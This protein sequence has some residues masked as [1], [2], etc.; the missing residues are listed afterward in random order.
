MVRFKIK[1]QSGWRAI[2]KRGFTSIEDAKIY[3]GKIRKLR[4]NNRFTPD[5][6]TTEIFKNVA[7]RRL[8]RNSKII[9]EAWDHEDLPRAGVYFI[10]PSAGGLIKIGYTDD[11]YKRFRQ[12]QYQC[13]VPLKVLGV[14]PGDTILEISFHMDFI[15]ERHHG[16]WFLPQGRVKEFLLELGLPFID[17][18][19]TYTKDWE[20][21]A[22][23]R[24]QEHFAKEEKKAANNKTYVPVLGTGK[25]LD[26]K[27][28]LVENK[29]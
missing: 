18:V 22:V 5:R 8:P 9:P 23:A 28:Q 24:L 4:Y 7:N 13:P 17:P 11:I 15:E 27:L 21:K 10:Q 2:T 29:Q 6:M 20:P 16:E 12:I 19:F 14:I 3:R 26:Q 1:D 25:T